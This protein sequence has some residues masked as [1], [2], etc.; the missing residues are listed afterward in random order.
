MQTYI[1]DKFLPPNS[2]YRK[3]SLGLW[4]EISFPHLSLVEVQQTNGWRWRRHY[5]F[6]QWFT[7]AFLFWYRTFLI[8]C[9]RTWKFSLCFTFAHLSCQRKEINLKTSKLDPQG[10][11]FTI[12]FPWLLQLLLSAPFLP[13]TCFYQDGGSYSSVQSR[14]RTIA[15]CKI[16]RASLR[17]TACALWDHGCNCA[18]STPDMFITRRKCRFC[19]RR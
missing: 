6:V 16:Y 9:G 7:K 5:F 14:A 8:I 19:R 10:Y 1:P 2:F 15:A 13:R 17:C 18:H 12:T 3:H 4:L 11:L